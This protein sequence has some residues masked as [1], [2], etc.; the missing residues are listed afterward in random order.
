M[1][2]V[3]KKQAATAKKEHRILRYFK[4]VR[5]EVRKIIWPSRR[6]TVNLTGIV[7]GVTVSMSIALGLVDWAFTKLFGLFI[8]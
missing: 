5:A 7:L 2:T 4:E 8:G 1:A 3:A 6:A